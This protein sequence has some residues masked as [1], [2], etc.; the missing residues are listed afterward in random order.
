MPEG[1]WI[2]VPATGETIH[3]RELEDNYWVDPLSGYHFRGGSKED[4]DILFD[5]GK[6]EEIA[7]DIMPT[8]PLNFVDRKKYSDRIIQSQQ[9][10]GLSDAWRVGDGE[11]DHLA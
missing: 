5:E 8:D 10:R 1:I 7:D 3:K 11:V 6:F 9:E 2:K 4:S